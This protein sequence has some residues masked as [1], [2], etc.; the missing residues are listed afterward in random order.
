[1]RVIFY[2]MWAQIKSKKKLKECFDVVTKYIQQLF[3]CYWTGNT[4][5]KV[6]EATSLGITDTMGA[7]PFQALPP[8][9]A[10]VAVQQPEDLPDA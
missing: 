1:M 4:E 5:E 3:E 7:N 8:E 2:H 9:I 10:M 6:Q